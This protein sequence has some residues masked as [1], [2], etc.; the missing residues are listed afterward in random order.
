MRILNPFTRILIVLL[1]ITISS[2]KEDSLSPEEEHFEAIGTIIYDATGAVAVSILRGVTADTLSIKEGELSDHFNIKFYDEEENI[3]DP[4]IDDH[5][6]LG[7]AITDKSIVEWW[8]HPGE[9][10]GYE[11]H[12]RGL[13]SGVTEIELLIVHEGH[14]DYRSGK[15]PVKVTP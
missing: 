13:K 4:P 15:I 6:K 2:C 11:F 3:I 10:G 1:I 8:Q 12:L 9:E 14:N 5:V 7:Y